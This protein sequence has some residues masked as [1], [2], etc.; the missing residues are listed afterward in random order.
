LARCRFKAIIYGGKVSSLAD[1]NALILFE[2][3]E[4]T[5][6]E[7]IPRLR[8]TAISFLENNFKNDSNFKKELKDLIVKYPTDNK[9]GF[10]QYYKDKKRSFISSLLRFLGKQMGNSYNI[11]RI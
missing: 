10:L 1:V 3:L 2:H 9:A 11:A 7:V 6:L 4:L 5:A 8:R